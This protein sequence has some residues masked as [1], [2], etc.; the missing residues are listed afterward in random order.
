M[1]GTAGVLLG[2]LLMLQLAFFFFGNEIYRESILLGFRRYAATFEEKQKPSLYFADISFNLINGSFSLQE[3][4]LSIYLEDRPGADHLSLEVPEVQVNGFGL[5]DILR[6]R[7]LALGEISLLKPRI[8]LL[9]GGVL[10]DSS[11]VDADE[12]LHKL[13]ERLL[14][15]VN[16]Y[17]NAFSVERVRISEANLFIT[18]QSV[19]DRGEDASLHNKLIAENISISLLDFAVD[20]LSTQNRERIFFSENLEFRLGSYQ[21]LLPDSSYLLRAD[22][23]GFS[24]AGQELFFKELRIYPMRMLPDSARTRFRLSLPEVR[25]SGVNLRQI[26]K[27][28]VLLA[29]KLLLREAR[30]SLQLGGSDTVSYPAF[31]LASLCGDRLLPFL[32]EMLKTA[33]IGEIKLE[34][35]AINLDRGEADSLQVMQASGVEI[36]LRQFLL[37]SLSAADSLPRL[38]ASDSLLLA[39]GH[40]RIW[41][42]DGRHALSGKCLKLGLG[43]E[44]AYAASLQLDSLR[45]RP[46]HDSLELLLLAPPQK[47]L[48]YELDVP[49][50]SISGLQLDSL[51]TSRAAV[52]DSIYI[53]RPD[54]R[55]ANFAE[56]SVGKQAAGYPVL[57]RS[58]SLPRESIR[59]LLYDWS[60]ARLN[61]APVIV[62]GDSAAWLQGLRA[63]QF[64]IDSGR[65]SVVKAAPSGDRFVEITRIDT[66]YAYLHQIRIDELSEDSAAFNTD[67]KVAVRA[68]D[69]DIFLQNSRFRVPGSRGEGGAVFVKDAR[70]NTLDSLGYMRNLYFSTNPGAPPSTSLWLQRMHLPYVQLEDIDLNRVYKEQRAVAG[71]LSIYAPDLVFN[72]YD[73]RS[74]PAGTFDFENLYPLLADY[75]H[76]LSLRRIRL[77]RG[78][79]LLRRYTAGRY[80]TLFHTR[81]LSLD[82]YDFRL[83]KGTRMSRLRPFYAHQLVLEADDWRWNFLAAA[84]EQLIRGLRAAKFHYNSLESQLDIEQI[85]TVTDAR[86]SDKTLDQQLACEWLKIDD[87]DPY[88]LIS[89]NLLHI[90]R[91]I[92]RR[93][94]FAVEQIAGDGENERDTNQRLTLQPELNRLLNEKLKRIE[95]G[96]FQVEEGVFKVLRKLGGD[97]TLYAYLDDIEL[98][99]ASILVDGRQRRHLHHVLYA[100]E[101]DFELLAQ[102]LRFTHPAKKQWLLAEKLRLNSRE[103]SLLA[104]DFRLFPSSPGR[105]AFS[106]DTRGMEVS[107]LDYR[108]AFLY[109]QLDVQEIDLLA[110]ELQL[111]VSPSGNKQIRD[112]PESVHHFISPY[113]SSISL[114]RLNYR[115]GKLQV[116]DR[117]KDQLMFEAPAID[118]RVRGFFLDQQAYR[119][120]VEQ[121][122]KG[123]EGLFFCQDIEAE[124]PAYSFEIDEGFY[125][126]SFGNISLSSGGASMQVED[127]RLQPLLSREEVIKRFAKA[128]TVASAE[129][130]AVHLSGVNFRKLIRQKYLDVEQV[131]VEQP[132]LKAYRDKRRPTDEDRSP[133]L[134][135]QMLLK[136]DQLL[137]IRHLEVEDG[138]ISYSERAGGGEED[139]TITFEG[140]HAG[141]R[142]LTNDRRL[143]HDSLYMRLDVSARVMGEGDLRVSFS[144]P[145]EDD[146]L[147]F[148]VSGNLG[149]MDLTHFN[150]ILEPVAFVHIKEGRARSMG[151]AFSGNRHFTEGVMR[152]KYNDLSVLM[153][154][155]QRGRVG[156]DEKLGS[157]IA[158][159]F[160]LKADNPK[161][162]F[163]RIGKIHYERDPSKAMFHY[164]WHS[165]LTGIKSSIMIEKETEKTKDFSTWQ[166]KDD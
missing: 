20:S 74:A 133:P 101:V 158:N 5:R 90:G 150:R 13:S 115:D 99:A 30:L 32:P 53:L 61:F 135:Q 153:L 108:K 155:K 27:D 52:V 125:R 119:A 94:V 69:M 39:A 146:S 134:H 73:N 112:Y 65:V 54:F 47:P 51:L 8:Q 128:K 33:G 147:A 1:L 157:I 142:N 56:V 137:N 48:A 118:A 122:K 139:G 127:V 156:F 77:S 149:P 36:V 16:Q 132:L 117:D 67:G 71:R 120:E 166:P 70:L 89:D 116:F 38:L 42:P 34:H 110:P 44:N 143:W 6:H 154:D 76:E 123:N 103:T 141:L 11:H 66:F 161:G 104:D 102:E 144:F 87:I 12:L 164:W 151:F 100:D 105:S 15:T 91:M 97:T 3:L 19:N 114:S 162:V 28:S 31:Q 148:S 111:F 88:R 2:L 41:L 21:W 163:M 50:F 79:A 106:L 45:L 121:L 113:L 68:S 17:L 140:L 109:G 130:R 23:L 92:A 24:T 58:D 62:P 80:D 75:L 84:D 86:Y 57:Q 160:V 81:R 138:F 40:F 46:G 145:L 83:H 82:M 64:Q 159:A 7:E 25:L 131:R 107:G 129:A 37:D 9:Q 152:F 96:S 85:A 10:Q 165:L 4:S 136:M 93:P 26:I 22:T 29:D 72:Y 95:V 98:T 18:Q 49:R 14:I 126:M 63:G 60:H 55:I 59:S 124:I 78:K 43:R 35:G